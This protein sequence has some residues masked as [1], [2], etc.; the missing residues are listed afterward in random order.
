[1]SL[2]VMTRQTQQTQQ[3]ERTRQTRHTQP[4]A[5]P[6]PGAATAAPHGTA[7]AAVWSARPACA[8]LDPGVVFARRAKDAAP[9]L[10]ACAR[11]TLH[12]ACEAVVAPAETWFDGVCAGRLW[13][14]GRPVAALDARSPAPGPL[15][16][17]SARAGSTTP[18]GPA[19]RSVRRERP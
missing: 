6:A 18:A 14:N 15:P 4:S 2:P 5:A 1:M 10:R 17:P 13:R 7:V 11:C 3:T 8:G 16:A 12:Q 19:L 9:A